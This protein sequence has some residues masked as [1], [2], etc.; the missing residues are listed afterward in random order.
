MLDAFQTKLGAFQPE[1]L[2]SKFSSGVIN[3]SLKTAHSGGGTTLQIC[4]AMF[5]I[6]GAHAECY[7][8]TL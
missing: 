3:L 8:L 2:G 1:E 5:L 4:G 6:G 7:G